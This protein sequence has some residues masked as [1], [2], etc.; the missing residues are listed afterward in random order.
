MAFC[1]TGPLRD[2]IARAVPDRPYTI[3][4]RHG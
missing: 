2:G 4:L 1:D 3:R